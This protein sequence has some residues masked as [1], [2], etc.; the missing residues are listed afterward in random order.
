MP[1]KLK[2]IEK[3]AKR[4]AKENREN[5]PD[6]KK[7]YWFPHE[8]EVRLVEVHKTIPKSLDGEIRPFYFRADPKAKLPAPS[9]IALIR[10]DEVK[11]LAPPS[12]WGSWELA[13]ELK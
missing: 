6:I 13:E 10:P 11:K 4:L 9:G 12:D 7:V 2:V 3:Q 8:G 5:D 1:T